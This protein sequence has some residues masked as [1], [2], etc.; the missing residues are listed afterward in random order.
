MVGPNWPYT[1]EIDIIE[2][3][4][5]VSS[6]Q[7]TLH[8]STG[9]TVSVGTGGQTG[10]STGDPSCGDGGGY[11]GCPV[12]SN[13]GSS[14]GTPFDNQG[15]GVYATEWTQSQIMIWY[16]PETQ[17]PSDIT[18]GNPN[19][20]GWGTPQANFAGCDFYSYMQNLNIVRRLRSMN[21]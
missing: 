6:N 13:T 2:G 1:G 19:P 7:M 11:N 17:V 9:C 18:S 3:V 16:W 10:S 21:S 5:Q 12:V 8:T 15:G 4:N 20:A 14:Y